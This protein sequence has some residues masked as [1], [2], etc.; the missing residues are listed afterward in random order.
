[1]KIEGKDILAAVTL[2]GGWLSIL[3][4]GFVYALFW[5]A[6]NEPGYSGD[7]SLRLVALSF[8]SLGG[9]AFLSGHIYLIIKKTWALIFISWGVCVALLVGAITLLPILLIFMV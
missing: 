7:N 2:A 5:R 1:M 4:S 9:M 6:D 3:I 8:C